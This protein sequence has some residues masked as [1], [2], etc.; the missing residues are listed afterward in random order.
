[1]KLFLAFMALAMATMALAKDVRVRAHTRKDGTYVPAHTRST[2]DSIRNNNYGRKSA[3]SYGTKDRDS[4]N[5]GI[6]NQY[7]KD[8]NNDGLIDR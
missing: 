4:D 7:D 8:D 1:M 6:Y 5:D 3:N 2:N